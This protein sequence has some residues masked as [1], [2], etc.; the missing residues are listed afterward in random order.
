MKKICTKAL[1]AGMALC[2]A[3]SAAACNKLPVGGDESNICEVKAIVA[4][5]GVD[6]LQPAVDQ[7][8]EM[9]KEEGYEVR[10][11]LTDTD[12]NASNEICT[13]NR[14][15]TDLY[16]SYS[17]IDTLINKS[18]SILRESGVSLLEDL[19][20]VWE[21]KAIGA[22]KQEQG[23]PI[24]ERLDPRAAEFCSYNGALDGFDG[25]Y[26]IPYEGGTTGIYV[27]MK[28]LEEKGYSEDDL[29]TTDALIEM[30]R[31]LAPADPLDDTQFFPVAWSGG[32]APGYWDYLC[33]ILIAQYAGAEKYGN[34][35]NFIPEEGESAM[36]EK[37]YEV[38]EEWGIYEAL[39][40]LEELENKDYAVPGTSSMTHT[41]AQ[42]R[43]FTGS[44]LF[45][46][47]G[48]WIYKEMEKDYGQYLDDVIAFPAPVISALGVK[49]GLCGRTHTESY[50]NYDCDECENILRAVVKAVDEDELGD[51]E[52]ASANGISA[53][54]VAV[55]RESRGYYRGHT[56]QTTVFMPSYSDAKKVAKLFLRFL[57]SDDGNDI[58]HR[59]TYNYFPIE[60]VE[61]P[62]VSTMNEREKAVYMKRYSE[63]ASPV[64]EDTSSPI[65]SIAKVVFFPSQGS[66]V[67]AYT[68]LSY[69]HSQGQATYT[70]KEIYESNIE[71]AEVSWND[72]LQT[73]R[74]I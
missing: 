61:E 27:N 25:L 14:N 73:A 30:V 69:S 71:F 12:I 17:T 50:E 23:D 35:W 44:S 59:Y 1:A 54:K 37:G 33:Q 70:A 4:G 6:W 24:G 68:G 28:V 45:M 38:Y 16:F 47:S 8:N 3:V 10:I 62:D 74:L 57:Y 53:D 51:E 56:G 42:A 46:V 41:A 13:P 26:G 66:Q 31:E 9:Y 32:K 49:L 43:V 48:D 64:Y 7:F 60:F 55:I 67:T 40:V 2:V 20:D 29:L 65:R 39:K 58:Y 52:I 21:S 19:S 36:L 22:D 15:T 34:I 63:N 5:Y 18:R 11:T 72:W